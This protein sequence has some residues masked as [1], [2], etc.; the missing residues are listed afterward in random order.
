[1]SKYLKHTGIP[2]NISQIH[3]Y[4]TIALVSELIL[5]Q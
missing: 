1:M 3:N 4:I 2:N 5:Q